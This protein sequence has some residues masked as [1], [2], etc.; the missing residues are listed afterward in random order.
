MQ[1]RDP[2]GREGGRH[3]ERKAEVAERV[4]LTS[5]R[6]GHVRA[7]RR[8]RRSQL[9]HRA[10]DRVNAQ[11]GFERG[12]VRQVAAGPGAHPPR[13]HVAEQPLD[14]VHQRMMI[15]PEPIPLD[16]RELGVVKP[17]ALSVAEY[18][19]DLV[20]VRRAGTE[21]ALHRVFRRGVQE[22]GALAP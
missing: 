9:G 16:H 4:A 22:P 15:D 8:Q 17:A 21:Q 3:V 1:E 10:V 20:D 19:R 6:G 11:A 14:V 12:P 13:E 2:I 5:E 18:L 7:A